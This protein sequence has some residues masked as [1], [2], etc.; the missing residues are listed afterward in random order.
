MKWNITNVCKSSFPY[1]S[2]Y[3]MAVWVI[4]VHERWRGHTGYRLSLTFDPCQSV[5]S[6][7]LKSYVLPGVRVSV[8]KARFT[9]L[10][11]GAWMERGET[12]RPENTHTNKILTCS[13]L[14]LMEYIYVQCGRTK[15][16][17][18]LTDNRH[19]L[20]IIDYA[21]TCMWS[22]YHPP[23]PSPSFPIFTRIFF[24]LGGGL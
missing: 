1:D 4:H 15:T 19:L 11:R 9:P 21:T 2:V 24:F 10:P 22:P 17:L 23:T 6:S 16:A 14:Y 20:S 7:G 12:S 5:G 8:K 18:P 13:L 3:F